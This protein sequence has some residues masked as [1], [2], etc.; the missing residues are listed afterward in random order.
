M[1]VTQQAIRELSNA[2]V[3]LMV[4]AVGA[5]VF[6]RA[7]LRALVASLVLAAVVGALVLLNGIR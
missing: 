4:I 3:L 1:F 6:W 2:K 7:A 5:I